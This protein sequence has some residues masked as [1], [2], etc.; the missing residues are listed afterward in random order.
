MLSS[1]ATDIFGKS[2]RNIMQA[3]LESKSLDEDLL[4]DLVLG[5]LRRLLLGGRTTRRFTACVCK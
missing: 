4:S 5:K 3:M 1:V 2:G